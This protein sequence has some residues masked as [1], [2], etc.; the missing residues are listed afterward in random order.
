MDNRKCPTMQPL[1]YTILRR[2]TVPG[3]LSPRALMVRIVALSRVVE[4][5]EVNR[6]TYRIPVAVANAVKRWSALIVAWPILWSCAQPAPPMPAPQPPKPVVSYI[7]IPIAIELDAI[8]RAA[9]AALQRSVGIQP[10]QQALN[11]GSSAPSCGEDVGYSIERGPIA[12]SGTGTMLTTTVDLN[13]WLKARKQLPCPGTA[14]SA[15]CGIDGE[16]ARTARVAIDSEISILPNLATSVQSK[17]QRATAG[18]QCVMQPM[19]LDI[20]EPLMVAFG[21]TLSQILPALDARMSAELDLRA[22]IEAAWHRISEPRELRP[23]VWLVWNPEALGIVPVTVSDGALRTGLQLRVRPVIVTGAKFATDPKPLPLAYGATHD[24]NFRLQ[25]PV[26]VEES[27]IQASLDKALNIDQGGMEV[28]I[29]RYKIRVISADITGEGSQVLIKARFSGDFSGTFNL[30]GTPYLDPDTQ[31]LNFPDLD[32]TLDSD[33]VLLQSASFV[34]HSQIRD[35]LREQYTIP[36]SSRISQFKGQIDSLLNRRNGN[37]QLHGTVEDLN[38][39]GISRPANGAVFTV[40][41]AARG[42]VSAEVLAP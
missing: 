41:L 42:K 36:L 4:C 1:I 40:Y 30:A 15:W 11:G 19:G 21:T 9:D 25:I 22:R 33:Q 32:Y 16:P 31:V 17:L 29:G 6:S 24:D 34:A 39:L 28:T 7:N 14:I 37:V 18:N 10:F 26:E 38:L 35:R 2:L 13:Y 5:I 8:E 27:F 12:L 3:Y 23:N 20:T